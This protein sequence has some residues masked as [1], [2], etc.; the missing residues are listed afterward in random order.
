MKNFEI[1]CRFVLINLFILSIGS[2]GRG[3]ME[4][5]VLLEALTFAIWFWMAN[6]VGI[7][8]FLGWMKLTDVHNVW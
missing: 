6:L 2:A 7:G 8:L 4:P 3:F 5:V 1:V